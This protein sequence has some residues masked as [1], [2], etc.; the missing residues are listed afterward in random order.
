MII[1][2]ISRASNND[3]QANCTDL[4]KIL[5][6]L[7]IPKVMRSFVFCIC[8]RIMGKY[9]LFLFVLKIILLR[10]KVGLCLHG[11]IYIYIYL[12]N[13]LF[14]CCRHMNIHGNIDFFSLT[15]TVYS[16]QEVL[17]IL[18][19]PQIRHTLNQLHALKSQW[20]V[21]RGQE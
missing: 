16:F 2:E 1:F 19:Q 17:S 7:S 15:E 5:I 13:W 4:Y 6:G 21:G 8:M 14:W 9:G 11:H 18:L 12:D 10:H 20:P 3:F